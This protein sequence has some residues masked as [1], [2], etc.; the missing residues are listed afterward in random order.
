[1][2][3]EGGRNIVDWR[4]WLVNGFYL[5][6]IITLQEYLQH[7]IVLAASLALAAGDVAVLAISL[8]FISLIRFGVLSVNM[9][10]SPKIARAMARADHQERDRQLR[11]AALL[12]APPAAIAAAVVIL[13]AGPILSLFG[14]EYMQGGRALAWFAAI[15]LASALLG[16]NHL[17]LNISGARGWVF[18]ISLAAVAALFAAVPA[19]GGV[20]PAAMIAALVYIAWELALFVVV[21][22]KLGIDA[23]VLAIFGRRR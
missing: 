8:R 22:T 6:P 12:K 2:G 7:C 15:P 3:S 5:S 16:P 23:T 20:E 21:R 1:M 14:P 13:L 9:A 4:N 11:A 18:G 17:L 10:A 19:A